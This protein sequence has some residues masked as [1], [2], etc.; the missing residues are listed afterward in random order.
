MR[1]KWESVHKLFITGRG[2]NSLVHLQVNKDGG[3][4]NLACFV[5][6]NVEFIKGAFHQNSGWKQ[7]FEENLGNIYFAVRCIPLTEGTIVW[8]VDHRNNVP[9][10]SLSYAPGVFLD[11]LI[12]T[13]KK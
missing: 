2:S 9:G 4:Q 8:I 11:Q 10:D 1:V 7:I 6:E 13:Y 12:E 5:P 3:F